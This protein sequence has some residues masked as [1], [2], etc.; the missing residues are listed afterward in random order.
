[1]VISNVLLYCYEQTI[2]KDYKKAIDIVYIM[3][4]A[5]NNLDTN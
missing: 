5:E 1:M 3:V 4:I 2:L